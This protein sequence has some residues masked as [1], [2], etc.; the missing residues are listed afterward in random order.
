MAQF[1]K[2]NSDLKGVLNYDVGS[3]T[4]DAIIL[5]GYI[6]GTTLTVV[7]VPNGPVIAGTASAPK[8]LVGAGVGTGT[9][10]TAVTG[11]S[12]NPTSLTV[13]VSQTVGSV[14]APVQFAVKSFVTAD[15]TIQPQ[16][17]KL[18]VF[19]VS[20]T[21]APAFADAIMKVVQQRATVHMYEVKSSTTDIAFLTYGTECWSFGSGDAND[22]DIAL[23]DAGL[24]A[25]SSAS[26][27]SFTG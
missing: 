26:G 5:S 19:T 21:A 4:N 16:G 9:I 24:G 2:Q 14:T 10:V 20:G 6:S 3:Y 25:F 17:P 22:L 23:S 8:Y 15:L 13:S 12:T 7:G 27:A 18:Q 1:L 11:S